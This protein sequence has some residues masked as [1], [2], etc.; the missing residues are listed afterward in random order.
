MNTT[1]RRQ[2]R[3]AARK[4]K[5]TA[6]AGGGQPDYRELSWNELRAYAAAHGVSTH[7]RTKAQILADLL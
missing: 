2:R 7:R 6:R 3:H 1:Q 5:A 4:A